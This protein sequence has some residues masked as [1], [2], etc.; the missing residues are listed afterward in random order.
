MMTFALLL[1]KSIVFA[2]LEVADAV[3]E[4]P[5]YLGGLDEP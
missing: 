3:K 2:L 4:R 1:V 5:P